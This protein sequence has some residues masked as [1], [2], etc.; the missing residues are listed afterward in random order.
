[1]SFFAQGLL[2]AGRNVLEQ[3]FISQKKCELLLDILVNMTEIDHQ[4]DDDFDK[5]L[6]ANYETLD[7]GNYIYPMVDGIQYLGGVKVT[8]NPKT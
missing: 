1:M 6:N 3:S 7:D 8:N 2:T 4:L 5:A